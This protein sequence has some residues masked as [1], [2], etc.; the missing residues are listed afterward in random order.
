MLPPGM[1]KRCE[2]GHT[3]VAVLVGLEAETLPS[4]PLG[5]LSEL[6]MDGNPIPLR[7]P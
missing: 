3:D 5:P 7:A 4:P 2:L 1:A 6:P